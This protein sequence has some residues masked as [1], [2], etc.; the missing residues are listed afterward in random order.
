MCAFLCQ[1]PIEVPTKVGQFVGIHGDEEI[2][3]LSLAA[4]V[5]RDSKAVND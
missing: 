1:G 5:K 2:A 3:R 4:L